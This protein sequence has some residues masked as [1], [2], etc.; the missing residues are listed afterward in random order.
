MS[1]AMNR[2]PLLLAASLA[3]PV[4][5]RAC[6]TVEYA[7]ALGEPIRVTD[8]S[9]LIVW[10]ARTGTE[11][12]VRRAE[13]ATHAKGFGFLVPTPTKPTLGAADDALFNDLE[14][15]LLPKKKVVAE[16]GL[17]LTPLLFT[18]LGGWG[19]PLED[20]ASESVSNSPASAA[21]KPAVEV[22]EQ[23]R[24]GDYNASVL[25]AGDTATLAA[26]LRAHNYA[27]SPDT[28][29]W[30]AG[31][32][33]QNF[34]ITAFQ[35]VADAQNGNAQ[36]GAVRLSFKTAAPFYPY[37]E[38][39]RAQKMGGGRSLRVF[40][41]GDGR[42]EGRIED[43]SRVAPWKSA[44]DYSAPLDAQRLRAQGLAVPSGALRLTAFTDNSSPRPGWGD[45]KFAPSKDQAEITPPPVIIHEDQRFP[46]PLDVLAVLGIGGVW[47][48]RRRQGQSETRAAAD[49]G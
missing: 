49:I 19:K 18:M 20:S 43:G 27:V 24:V 22:V 13:F 16:R 34:Y 14:F 48:W 45:L 35:I 26:W 23:K 5:C 33:R 38:S 12:F 7:H 40:F 30:L 28:R 25:R 10:N 47:A 8:E 15:E 9:A 36:A 17:N 21:D 1:N 42:V 32:V 4:A 3:L 37:R 44:V 41:V 6:I 39:K 46:L 2:L 31:Y 11:D 29:D